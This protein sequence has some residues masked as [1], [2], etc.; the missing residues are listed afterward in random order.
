[1]KYLVIDIETGPQSESDVMRFA[2]EFAAPSNYKDEAK[3]ER[4]LAVKRL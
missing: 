1:M 4:T 3:I 2:P